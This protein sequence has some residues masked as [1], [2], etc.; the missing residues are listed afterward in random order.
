MN[1]QG[2]K[3]KVETKEATTISMV[4]CPECGA[5]INAPSDVMLKEILSCPDCGLELEVAKIEGQNL[6]LKKILIEKED[7]GE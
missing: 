5:E 3:L 7:W 2:A 1:A 4:S 6:E